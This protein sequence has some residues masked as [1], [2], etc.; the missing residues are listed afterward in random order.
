MRWV[1][2]WLRGKSLQLVLPG[3]GG[4]SF[5]LICAPHLSVE[6]GRWMKAGRQRRW[7]TK[8]VATHAWKK[9]KKKKQTA[10]R[11]STETERRMWFIPDEVAC[12]TGGWRLNQS[13][14]KKGEWA[15]KWKSKR[16]EKS[17][18]C[19]YTGG[20]AKRQKGEEGGLGRTQLGKEGDSKG[21]NQEIQGGDN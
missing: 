2:E 17:T 20:V 16:F 6:L 12:W 3:A 13:E 8:L 15:K 7:P 19:L 1:D 21:A 4:V 14:N 18:K 11:S 9:K 10:G 5:V